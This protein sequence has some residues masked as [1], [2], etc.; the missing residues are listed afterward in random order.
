MIES[1]SERSKRAIYEDHWE[2]FY[3]IPIYLRE[4]LKIISD[5]EN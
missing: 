4:P 5:T 2:W 3:K 1:I